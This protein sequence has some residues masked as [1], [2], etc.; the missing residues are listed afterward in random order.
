MDGPKGALKGIVNFSYLTNQTIEGRRHGVLRLQRMDEHGMLLQGFLGGPVLQTVATLHVSLRN[1]IGMTEQ[2][3]LEVGIVAQRSRTLRARYAE[4]YGLSTFLHLIGWWLE[5]T[6]V[7][8]LQWS[9]FFFF[10][11]RGSTSLL[12]WPI[13]GAQIGRAAGCFLLFFLQLFQQNLFR[14]F[15]SCRRGR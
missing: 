10:F 14:C 6:I 13:E 2:M 3:I 8:G 15:W 5:L 1:G 7:V 11:R 4:L 9:Q 12:R